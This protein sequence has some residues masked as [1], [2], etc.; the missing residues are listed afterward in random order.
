MSVWI[1]ANSSTALPSVIWASHVC[2]HAIA[3]VSASSASAGSALRTCSATL[4]GLISIVTPGYSAAIAPSASLILRSSAFAASSMPWTKPVSNS[5]PWLP[6]RCT[7]AGIRDSVARSRSAR[8]EISA[9][10]VDGSAASARSAAADS[11]SGRAS[12]GLATIGAMVPSKSEATSSR[13]TRA[14]VARARFSSAGNSCV[15]R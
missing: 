8:P 9:A 10:T 4:A 1:T 14:T 2:A 11:V 6:T 12:A 13:G 3:F 7:S 15:T 5:E